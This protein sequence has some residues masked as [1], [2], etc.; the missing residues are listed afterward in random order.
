[1]NAKNQLTRPALGAG[2]WFPGTTTQLKQTIAEQFEN[3]FIPEVKNPI[4]AVIAPHAG[5][6]YSG[7]TAAYTYRAI[8]E[9]NLIHGAPDTV[10]ILGFSHREQNQ[11]VA[12]MD[13]DTFSTP[14]GATPLDKDCAS[15]LVKADS[16]IKFDYRPHMG[17]HSLEN[18]V[19]FI[20]TVMPAASLVMA[21]IGPRDMDLLDALAT[22][23]KKLAVKKKI[24]VVASSDMLHDPSYE[25]VRKTDQA[26]LRKVIGMDIQGIMHD[27]DFSHQIFCGIGPVVTAMSYAQQQGC[28]KAT[29]L[30]YRNSGDDF[31]ESRGEWVV[32]YGAIAFTA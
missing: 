20:Q 18:Q 4:V 8:Q 6:V 5:Y 14:L 12:I 32:G 22:A 10:V 3:A 15:L 11:G 24:L 28:K 17:E 9:N 25:R 29:L 7:P 2:K 23:L 16:R 1:M 30:R 31:P 21:M 13:G 19:P 27:W 26:T